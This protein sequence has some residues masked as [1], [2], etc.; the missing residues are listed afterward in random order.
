MLGPKFSRRERAA[1]NLRR[2]LAVRQ[3]EYCRN[4]VFRRHFPIHRLF[5]RSCELGLWRWTADHFSQVFGIRLTRW[6]KDKLHTTLEKIEHG[7]H[8]FRAYWKNSLVKQYEKF[9][10][11]LRLEVCSNNVADFPHLQPVSQLEAAY[12]QADAA[13]QH[14]IQLL[15]AA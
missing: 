9:L 5:E 6:L 1:M 10:T 4:F 3:V 15:E 8:I 12:H 2:F 11:F 14:I 13:L 7:H